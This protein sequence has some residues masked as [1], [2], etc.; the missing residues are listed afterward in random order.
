M[1]VLEANGAQPQKQPHYGIIFLDRTFTGLYTQRP[2]L[3][4]PSDV[5][6]A[7]YYGGRPDALLSGRNV[8]LTNGNTLKRRPGMVPFRVGP[9]E[10]AAYS[11][12]P[13]RAF[14]FQLADGTIQVIIDTESSGALAITAAASAVGS[15]TTYTGTFPGGASNGYAGLT[16][17][18][19]GFSTNP[20]N[21]G[22]FTCTASTLTTLT[23]SNSSGVA[24]TNAATAITAGGVYKD[25]MDGTATLLYA[26]SVGAGQMYFISVAGVLYMGDG[27]DTKKYTPL[28][29]NGTIWNWGIVAPTKPP[30]VTI[31]SSGAASTTWQ[32]TTVFSTMGLTKD[33]NATPQ[34]WQIIGTNADGTNP[35]NTQ[36]GTTGNGEPVW[37]TVEGNTVTD[38]T[39]TWTNAGVLNDWAAN[40]FFTD[41]GYFGHV[42][43]P[44]YAQP[45]AIAVA[46]ATTIYGNYKNSGGLGNTGSAGHE[47]HFSSA[48]PGSSYFDNNTHWFA[49]GSYSTPTR[50]QQMRWKPTHA[51]SG[52]QSGGSSSSTSGTPGF[53]LTG[54]LPAPPGTPV[55]LM[56]PTTGGTSSSGYQPFPPSAGIGF[57]QGDGQVTWLCLGQAA[58]QSNHA[59]TKW[60]AQGLTFGCIYD[61]ANFQVCTATTG[62]GQSGSLTP[63]TAIATAVSISAANAVGANTTYTLGSGSWAHTPSSGD[64]INISGFVTNPAQNNGLFQV[65]S[66]TSNTITVANPSGIAETHSA[67]IAL[68]PWATAYGSTTTD[69][70]VTWTC[71]GPN[72]AW[73]GS[74]TWNL[75][76]VGF[77]PP[78]PSQAYGGSSIDAPNSFVQAVTSSGTS[79][80]S[81]PVFA[82]PT[83][84]PPTTTDGTITWQAISAVTTQSIAWSFGLAY[85]YSY[86]ARPVDD[87]YSPLPLG[88]GNI[89]PGG[90]ALGAP[91]GSETNAISSASPDFQIVGPNTGAVNL[92][93]GEYSPDPQCDTIII[94][95][96]ADSADGGDNMFELTEIP[97]IPSQAGIT[98]WSFNDFLPSVSDGTY[99]GLNVLLPAPI[100]G[101]NDP[102]LSTYKPMA[103][104]FSR[105]WGSN[106]SDVNFSGGPDTNVGNPNEAF[107]ISDELPFLAPVVRLIRTPQGLVTFLTDSIEMIQ[108]GPTTAS[109]FSTTMAP[110]VGLLSFNACDVFAGEIYFFSADKKF[111]TITPSLN[112]ANYGFP[113]GD[114]FANQPI[115]GV[116]D[117][118]WDPSEVYVAVHQNGVDDCIFVCDG[119]T[120]WY[121]LNPHQVPGA[122]QGP[123]PVWSPYAV[124][125]DGCKMV[126]SVE[127]SAGVFQLLA[128]GIEPG[129][130]IL[131]RDL[132]VFTDDGV[133]YDAYF[134]MG[135]IELGKPGQLAILKFL[136]FDFSGVAFQPT[137]SYLL[138]EIS[139][140]FSNFVNGTNNVPQFDP[141]SL[142]GD[143]FGPD[144]YSPNRYY[145]STTG[146]LA[147]CRHMQIK[148]DYGSTDVG[149]EMYSLA[150]VGRILVES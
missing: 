97:N 2:A 71:V 64:Q 31:Q 146:Q 46:S 51:Y 65:V 28:N 139:G 42:P 99:P 143:N 103:F 102:P 41:L 137:V 82:A 114:Q 73:S 52:W 130:N 25:N 121:R 147:R 124:I 77:Q 12:A 38:G 58:W 35:S 50:M 132:T 17:I 148:V 95:R 104:N 122:S 49:I 94:W 128:G 120:G 116:S 110:G 123:E 111:R 127:T 53:V 89:P 14:S 22:T 74:Q 136:E 140:T 135:S 85:A 57:T 108:G 1:T 60:T 70:G 19:A 131:A 90:V 55:Y 101:V 133:T 45:G 93:S 30:A 68:N 36:F 5:V 47:P 141:P 117:T 61:G 138:N 84:V 145:F 26:K 88:G 44:S 96:S 29:T 112:L 7:K 118:T 76:T 15:T 125:T 144:S 40:T 23:L 39:V 91:F 37:P 129:D 24:E 98:Q 83:D 87:F 11:T 149:N 119:S 106:G 48:Y 134:T 32:A 113:L 109:F 75:P 16:F 100:D 81:E 13:D 54:N 66:A 107:L 80:A 21:N 18:V 78:S 92:I 59:Y 126:Q 105:I 43:P 20:G 86:K 6:T 10:G 67:T 3:H 63:G 34:I 33:T 4:D 79:G 72:V 115:S 56:I 27:V 150:I 62:T 142:Y 9:G 69:G 8:E